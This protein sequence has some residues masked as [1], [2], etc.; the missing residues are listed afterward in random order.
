MKEFCDY[1]FRESVFQYFCRHPTYNSIRRNIF[2]D[3]SI[4]SYDGTITNGDSTKYRSITTYPNIIPYNA[5]LV[6]FVTRYNF[7]CF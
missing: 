1:I 5:G 2:I 7:F 4:S 3:Q 6:L